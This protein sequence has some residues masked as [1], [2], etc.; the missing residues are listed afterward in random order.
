MAAAA[1]PQAGAGVGYPAVGMQSS[2]DV[3]MLSSAEGSGLVQDEPELQVELS[4]VM[5]E[6]IEHRQ[7]EEDAACQPLGSGQL[8]GADTSASSATSPRSQPLDR[9]ALPANLQASF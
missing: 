1:A 2:G 3:G 8:S 6:L 5:G 4:R 7:L 9:A